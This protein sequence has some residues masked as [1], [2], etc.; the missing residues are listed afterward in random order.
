MSPGFRVFPAMTRLQVVDA[1]TVA[2][3]AGDFP[4]PRTPPHIFARLRIDPD[5]VHTLVPDS[6]RIN[7]GQDILPPRRLPAFDVGL[8]R[9]RRESIVQLQA[10]LPALSALESVL[11]HAALH[12]FNRGMLRVHNQAMNVGIPISFSL[13]IQN[14]CMSVA[15]RISGEVNAPFRKQ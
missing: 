1:A 14:R 12:R 4:Q 2:V 7:P 10:T 3:F 5:V 13:P 15:V 9:A 11:S 6:N 8:R